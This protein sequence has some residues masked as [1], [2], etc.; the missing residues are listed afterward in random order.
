MSDS[1]GKGLRALMFL[2]SARENRLGSR[3]KTFMVNQ[4]KSRGWEVDVVG[5]H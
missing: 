1:D 2:G 3:V 4:L 5:K